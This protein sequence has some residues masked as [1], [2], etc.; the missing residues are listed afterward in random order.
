MDPSIDLIVGGFY[1]R[2]D[3]MVWAI[4]RNLANHPSVLARLAR[5]ESTN[6]VGIVFIVGLF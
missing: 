5:L 6:E 1:N 4:E 3:L 2:F